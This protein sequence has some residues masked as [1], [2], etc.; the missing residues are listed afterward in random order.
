MNIE[1]TL[2]LSRALKRAPKVSEARLHVDNFKPFDSLKWQDIYGGEVIS[3]QPLVLKK[4]LRGDKSY[5][6][7]S[8][9]NIQYVERIEGSLEEVGEVPRD[10]ILFY[11]LID[12][13]TVN[14]DM[15]KMSPLRVKF[16][17]GGEI[18]SIPEEFLRDC[19]ATHI[20]FGDFEYLKEIGSHSFMDCRSLSVVSF[21]NLHSLRTLGDFTFFNCG[22]RGMTVHLGYVDESNDLEEVFTN[23]SSLVLYSS[24][25]F[26]VNELGYIFHLDVV[27]LLV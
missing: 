7:Y 18:E 10:S 24:I 6:S 9:L 23:C 4:S 27:K 5:F 16:L 19:K 11:T 15:L 26:M 20:Y 25:P 22:S 21:R 13:K 14:V 12:C 1:M 3:S 17:D 2:L 8:T